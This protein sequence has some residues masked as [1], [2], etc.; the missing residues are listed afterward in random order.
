M[1][2]AMR[3]PLRYGL[4][5]LALP[6]V[7]LVLTGCASSKKPVPP[8]VSITPNIGAP[9]ATATATISPGQTLVV[10]LPGFGSS[11]SNWTVVSPVDDVIASLGRKSE[12]EAYADI[13]EGASGGEWQTFRFRGQRPGTSTVRFTYGRPWEQSPP[14]QK[15]L[16][17]DVTVT[18]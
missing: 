10:R 14:M 6:A 9:N 7:L 18:P 4:S 12:G 5:L 15:R 17:L 8:D 3:I 16:S 13:S 11:E 1:E 2:D